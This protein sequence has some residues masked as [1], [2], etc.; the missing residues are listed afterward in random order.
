[1]VSQVGWAIFPDLIGHFFPGKLPEFEE[2]GKEIEA[3]P[4]PYERAPAP[5]L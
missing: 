2:L 5:T 1:M 3:S 4:A